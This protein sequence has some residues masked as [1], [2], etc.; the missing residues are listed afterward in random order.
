MA[1]GCVLLASSCFAISQRTLLSHIAQ[2]IAT[3]KMGRRERNVPAWR[4]QLRR[5][6][7]V[8]SAFLAVS[9]FVLSL[10]GVCISS[11]LPLRGRVAVYC[12]LVGWKPAP[13]MTLRPRINMFF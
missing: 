2:A 8:L 11:S 9:F 5:G 12:H 10:I 3:G 13:K 4:L 7:A 6:R 1:T